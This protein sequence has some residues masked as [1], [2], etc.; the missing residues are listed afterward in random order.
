LG[1]LQAEDDARYH[2]F[3]TLLSV[4]SDRSASSQNAP[5]ELLDGQQ[6]LAT[7]TLL[8]IAID[9][10]LEELERSTEASSAVRDAAREARGRIRQAIF[11]TSEDAEHR[12]LELRPEEDQLLSNIIHGNPPGKGKLGDAFRELH[13]AVRGLAEASSDLVTDLRRLVQVVLDRSILIHARCVHGFDPFAVFATLNARGLPLSASQVLR[14][15]MLGLVSEMPPGVHAL[16]KKAWDL[17]EDMNE[18]G[19][20]FLAYYLTT[21][22]GRRTPTKEVV[23]QFDREI[24][25]PLR[26]DPS[27]EPGFGALADELWSLGDLYRDIA[28]G[29]WP[30]GVAV[31]A[32]EWRKRRLRLL[33]QELGVKQAIPLILAVCSRAPDELVE[34]M[35]VIEQRSW[36]SCASRTRRS[37]GISSSSGREPCTSG[38]WS[39]RPSG[40]RSGSGSYSASGIPPGPWRSIS[41]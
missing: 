39:R 1:V 26:A 27:R 11:R 18:E 32:S 13:G 2:F 40:T 8:M 15:R 31:D 35:D 14:A 3:G 21:R 38:I 30:Q 10:E 34:V 12:R 24:L 16:T 36:R 22:T 20:R 9:R 7:F 28:K 41:P 6:R 19:D 25:T 37:G 5:L 17:V 4:E 33:T 29:N 23:R